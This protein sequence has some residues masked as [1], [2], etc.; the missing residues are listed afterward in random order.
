MKQ[1][2]LFIQGGGAGAYEADQ[3][4]VVSLGNALG[5]AYEVRYPKMRHESDPEYQNWKTRIG[6]ELAGLENDVILVGHSLGGS[7]LLKY[8]SDEKVEKNIAGIFLIATPYWGGNGWRYEGYESLALPKSFPSKVLSGTPIFFYHSRDD[9]I[10]PFA[11]LA[12]YA[13]KLP[14]AT[15]RVFDARGHQ[16]KNDLSEVAA[17]IKSL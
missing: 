7:F 14:Q 13:R 9:E 5:S 17:D 16:L 12:L 15:A 11:H 4:L 10:V 3:P 6:R 2:I 8:L 1:Q